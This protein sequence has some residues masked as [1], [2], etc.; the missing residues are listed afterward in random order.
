MTFSLLLKRLI[1]SHP[2]NHG[3]PSKPP[4]RTSD[5]SGAP[6]PHNENKAKEKK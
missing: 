2:S 1:I 6:L 5:E 3:P 4:Q